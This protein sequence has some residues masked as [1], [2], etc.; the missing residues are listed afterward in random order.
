MCLPLFISVFTKNV[1]R[2]Q[3]PVFDVMWI[4]R[5]DGETPGYETIPRHP[6]DVRFHISD[7]WG[8]KYSLTRYLGV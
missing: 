2:F 1:P 8:W 5:G 4:M 6:P 7:W 3:M